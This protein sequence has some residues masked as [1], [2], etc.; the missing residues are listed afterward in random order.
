MRTTNLREGSASEKLWA[1]QFELAISSTEHA[2][3]CLHAPAIRL[4]R[5]AHT[6]HDERRK[7]KYKS[8]SMN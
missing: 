8:S 1:S 7:E 6:T 3:R 5:A 4:T 2:T